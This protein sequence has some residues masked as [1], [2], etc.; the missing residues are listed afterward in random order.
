MPNDEKLNINEQRKC[1]KLVAPRCRK[2]NKAEGSRLPMEMGEV[3]GLPHKS[4][5]RLMGMPN[6]KRAARKITSRRWK[7]GSTAVGRYFSPVCLASAEEACYSSTKVTQ[8]VGEHR[9]QIY[10]ES[11]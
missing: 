4:L 11:R 7:Y 10:P 3:T 5:T 2:V 1:L 6:M 9:P 8:L